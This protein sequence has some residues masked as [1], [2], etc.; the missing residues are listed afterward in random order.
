V[1]SKKIASGIF[2]GLLSGPVGLLIAYLTGVVITAFQTREL[3]PTLLVAGTVLP[4]MLLLVLG[5]PTML[6]S[7]LAGL[8]IGLTSHFT[9]HCVLIGG[10]VGFLVGE[11]VLTLL[12]PRVVVPRPGDFTSIIINPLLSGSYGVLLGV[13]TGAFFLLFIKWNSS[14]H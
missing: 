12:L 10:F 7:V 1:S 5:I 11:L 6:I 9:R 4:L 8:T 2:A 3:L 14:P 13:M